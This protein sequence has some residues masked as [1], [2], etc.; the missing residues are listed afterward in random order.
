M[1][2][3]CLTSEVANKATTAQLNTEVCNSDHTLLMSPRSHTELWSKSTIIK[4]LNLILY[5]SV[6]A[7]AFYFIFL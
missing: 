7:F 4:M 5:M 3:V 6:L 1:L 2:S